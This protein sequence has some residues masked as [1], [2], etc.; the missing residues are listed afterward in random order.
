MAAS[1]VGECSLLKIFVRCQTINGMKPLNWKMIGSSLSS[2]RTPMTHQHQRHHP[3]LR[4]LYKAHKKEDE[5]F[6]KLMDASLENPYQVEDGDDPDEEVELVPHAEQPD[7]EPQD[8]QQPEEIVPSEKKVIKPIYDFR[9]VYRKLPDMATRDPIT[10]KRLLLG[11]HE[12]LWHCPIMDFRNILLR[13]NMPPEVIRLAAEAVGAC[14]I[15]RKFVRATRR[16][17]VKTDLAMN[18]NEVIQLDIFY[19]KGDMFLLVVDEA[20][21]YKSGGLLENRELHSIL[22]TLTNNLASVLWTT[23]ST[24]R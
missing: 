8:G 22:S 18:F 20:T 6:E 12:R 5:E 23:S 16:P 9:R 24:C 11:L 2:A 14:T 21:R 7:V 17:Q 13:C 19:Y 4:D 3:H 10:T 1:G 15:C